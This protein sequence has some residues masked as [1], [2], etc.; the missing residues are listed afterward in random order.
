MEDGGIWKLL[1]RI[2]LILG[3]FVDIVFVLQSA[4]RPTSRTYDRPILAER[5][6]M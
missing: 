6:G 5:F 3:L 1:G 4:R 2:A